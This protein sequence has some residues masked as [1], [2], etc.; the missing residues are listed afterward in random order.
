MQDF[1]VEDS[2]SSIRAVAL[3]VQY[4]STTALVNGPTDLLPRNRFPP[5]GYVIGT[6]LLPIVRY[7]SSSTEKK[8]KTCTWNCDEVAQE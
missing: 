8:Q 5:L 6:F 2:L 1:G 4:Y 3:P 7:G